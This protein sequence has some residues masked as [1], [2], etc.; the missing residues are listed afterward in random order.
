VNSRYSQQPE[1]RGSRD[2]F[3][4]GILLEESDSAVARG[5]GHFARWDLRC[6]V[7]ELQTWT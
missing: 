1:S 4:N 3:T 6:V 7:V 2:L 5:R